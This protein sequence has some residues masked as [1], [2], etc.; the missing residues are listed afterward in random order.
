MDYPHPKISIVDDKINIDNA[1][2]KNIGEWDKVSVKYAYSDFSN[3]QDESKELNKILDE[4]ESNGLYFITDSDSRPISS[5][6]PYS[7]LWDNGDLPYKELDNLLKIR[8]KA[9]KNLDLENLEHGE[10]YDRIED[11]MV[12][13]NMLHR[14]QIEATTSAESVVFRV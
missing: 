10:S 6:N 8:N 14:Y 7:H 12:P 4:A 9:L 13:I 1:Y 2:A 11:I 5:A 3:L